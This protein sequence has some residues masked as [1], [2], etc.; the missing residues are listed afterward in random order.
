VFNFQD[1]GCCSVSLRLLKNLNGNCVGSLSSLL[2][3]TKVFREVCFSSSTRTT[4]KY[5]SIFHVDRGLLVVMAFV[6]ACAALSNL[7]TNRS[8]DLLCF[9]N[10]WRDTQTSCSLE[11][12]N[13]P[14]SFDSKWRLFDLYTSDSSFRCFNQSPYI[15]TFVERHGG[16]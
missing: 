12:K 3:R 6:A 11:R 4:R 16:D 13:V 9:L 7:V 10:V 15:E 14:Y 8:C 1:R 5:R 2:F